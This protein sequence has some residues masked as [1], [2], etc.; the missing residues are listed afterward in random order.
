V[1]AAEVDID[2]AVL[3]HLQHVLKGAVKQDVGE[4]VAVPRAST[5]ILLVLFT[6]SMA[7]G[8]TRHPVPVVLPLYP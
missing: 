3:L 1:E 6:G 5:N 4:R 2:R 7:F 8:S